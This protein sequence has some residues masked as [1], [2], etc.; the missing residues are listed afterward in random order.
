MDEHLNW[1]YHN[2]KLCKKLFG[3]AGIFFKLRHHVSLPT[4]ICLYKSLFSY[5]LNYGITAW[6]LHTYETYLNPLL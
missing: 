2:A 6:G 3:T 4:L 1:K 5:F